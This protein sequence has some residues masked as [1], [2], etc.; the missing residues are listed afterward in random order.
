MPIVRGPRPDR[1]FTTIRN[2]VINDERLSFEARGIHE[3]LISKPDTWNLSVQ[4]LINQTK[5]SSRPSGKAKIYAAL[6]ELEEAGYL[7][8]QRLAAGGV[9]YTIY[10][11]P[12]SPENNESA[13]QSLAPYALSENREVA[14]EPLFN[15]QKVRAGNALPEKPLSQSP[16]VAN[17]TLV[18]TEV[19]EKTE[20]AEKGDSLRESPAAASISDRR[21][22][23]SVI[24]C[25][26]DEIVQAYHELMPENPRVKVLS[27]ARRRTIAARWKDA[28]SLTC[29][30]FGYA[31]VPTGVAAW[32]RFFE[33][34]ATSRFLT[35]QTAPTPGRP[36]FIADIDFLVSQSGFTKCLENKYHRD[37]EAA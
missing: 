8:R 31:D 23:A 12:R 36:R 27:D 4:D 30:P 21:K 20:N 18:K 14:S 5:R 16:L 37:Q 25:P 29:K 1:D 11:V 3:Y 24:P 7:C 22:K 15:N 35:G 6:K 32:R 2:S 33:I 26:V 9:E 28:S 17:R 10:D 34:C 19:V 13:A